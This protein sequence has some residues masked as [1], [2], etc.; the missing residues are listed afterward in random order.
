MPD[1]QI[2]KAAT[3]A[4]DGEQ[5]LVCEHHAGCRAYRLLAEPAAPAVIV[6]MADEPT[7]NFELDA[8][9]S[10]EQLVAAYQREISKYIK[11]KTDV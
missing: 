9:R 10:D 1:H 3:A 7:A 4:R 6:T 8:T 2:V 11:D 5:G